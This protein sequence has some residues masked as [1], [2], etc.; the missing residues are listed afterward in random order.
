MVWAYSLALVITVLVLPAVGSSSSCAPVNGGD[1]ATVRPEVQVHDLDLD[2]DGENERVTL[3]PGRGGI[4]IVDGATTYR[5][6]EKWTVIQAAIGD[7]DR[8][9]NPEVVA[10]LEEPRGRRLGLIGWHA[11]RYHERLVSSL[12]IPKPLAITIRDDPAHGGTVVIVLED[13]TVS[14]E[15]ATTT[16]RWNGFGFTAVEGRGAGS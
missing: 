12:L 15:G 3:A 5:S 14:G 4:V 8:D 6:R 9:G 7:S 11:G 13:P 16:Y 1:T 10:L 2:G